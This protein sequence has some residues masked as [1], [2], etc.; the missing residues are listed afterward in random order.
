MSADIKVIGQLKNAPHIKYVTTRHG[1][2]YSWYAS[3]RP[4]SVQLIRTGT[5]VEYRDDNLPET[6]S[7]QLR[8]DLGKVSKHF[9]GIKR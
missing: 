5:R 4:V 3:G 2:T 7:P 9:K 6:F 1:T 8:D